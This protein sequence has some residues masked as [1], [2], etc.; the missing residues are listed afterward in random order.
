MGGLVLTFVVSELPTPKPE[1]VKG[2]RRL[3]TVLSRRRESKIP[4][5]ADRISESPERKPKASGFGSFSNRLGRSKEMSPVLE[6]PQEEARERPRSPL[7]TVSSISEVSAPPGPPPGRHERPSV[8]GG[9]E[10]SASGAG[11]NVPNNSHQSDL[12]QLQQPLQPSAPVEP[13]KQVHQ[14]HPTTVRS[15]R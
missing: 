6:P 7:R 14:S 1:K 11:F 2:L 9:P 3:G 8:N 10:S 12:T 15:F 13:T 5:G 4:A